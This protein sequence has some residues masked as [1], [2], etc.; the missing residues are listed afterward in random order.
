MKR[1]NSSHFSYCTVVILTTLAYGTVHH[2]ILSL[3]YLTLSVILLLWAAEGLTS[4]RLRFSRSVLQIPLLLLGVYALVQIVPFGTF[5]EA[6]GLSGIP[7]TISVEPF[8]TQLTALQISGSVAFFPCA[9][10]VECRA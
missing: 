2:P 6:A 9:C 10:Y 4:G 8:A 3:F 5:A 7:R 1:L